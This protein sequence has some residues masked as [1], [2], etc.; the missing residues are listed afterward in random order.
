MKHPESRAEQ[1]APREIEVVHPSYQPSRAELDEDMRVE[2]A[3]EEAAEALAR[4]VRMRYTKR[5][6]EDTEL[7]APNRMNAWHGGGTISRVVSGASCKPQH[8]VLRE[9]LRGKR[10]YADQDY[11]SLWQEFPRSARTPVFPEAFPPST[12]TTATPYVCGG[13]GVLRCATD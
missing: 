8:V 10:W 1:S 7:T 4:P 12:E 13:F 11:C 2:A 6:R 5:P 9:H 3:F